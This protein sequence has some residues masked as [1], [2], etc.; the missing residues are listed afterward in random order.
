[1]K[2]RMLIVLGLLVGLLGSTAIAGG[3]GWTDDWEAAKKQAAE[4]G[5]DLLIDFTGS[6]W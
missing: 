2:M 4:E 3:E 1:M 6:D 5:K